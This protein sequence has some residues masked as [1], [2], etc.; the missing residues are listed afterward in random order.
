M[1]VTTSRWRHMLDVARRMG[2]IVHMWSHPENFTTAP[3]QLTL[4][5]EI[6]NIVG[7]LTREG[8]I[9]AMTQAEFC[10]VV[11]LGQVEQQG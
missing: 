9:Q 5:S 11:S 3:D 7:K 10:R 8:D 1:K 2:G 4:F 6:M